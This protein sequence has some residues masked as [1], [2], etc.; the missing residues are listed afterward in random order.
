MS[1]DR[2]LEIA[3]TAA[4]VLGTV[5]MVLG[6]LGLVRMPDVFTR[7]Q[8]SS[9]SSTLGVAA[10]FLAVALHFGE[11]RVTSQSLGVIVFAFISVPVGA[12]MITR[13]AHAA[14]CALWPPGAHDDL[15]EHS[16]RG[17]SDSEE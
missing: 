9:K 11:L 1:A 14:G 3:A 17:C 8:A 13:A 7:I 6:A 5:L 16:E 4:L 12:H 10:A 2:A 15:E